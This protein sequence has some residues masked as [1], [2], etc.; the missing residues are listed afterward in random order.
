MA[1]R[2]ANAVVNSIYIN[3]IGIPINPGDQ[4]WGNPLMAQ[5]FID[6]AAKAFEVRN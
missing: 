5:G 6:D 3:V 2:E 4:G 1:L